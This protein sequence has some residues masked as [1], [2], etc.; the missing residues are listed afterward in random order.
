MDQPSP[1]L[2]RRLRVGHWI[3]VDCVVTAILG[4]WYITVWRDL[5]FMRG[6]LWID[7][8]ILAV[9]VVP[10]AMRRRWPRAVL[11]AVVAGQI[12][13]NVIGAPA[14]PALVVAFVM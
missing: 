3:A 5:A 13:A 4:A 7:A 14:Q 1:P 6:P 12:V 10:A 11:I 2:L 8:V 9:A